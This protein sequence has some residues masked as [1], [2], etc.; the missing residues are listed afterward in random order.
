MIRRFW[1]MLTFL[2]LRQRLP[3][4]PH[5]PANKYTRADIDDSTARAFRL[6]AARDP[7]QVQI[8]MRR[9]KAKSIDD[10]M[11]ILERN[12][13]PRRADRA[14]RFKDWVTFLFGWW[15]YEPVVKPHSRRMIKEGRAENEDPTRF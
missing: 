7:R 11:M 5:R 12:R 6:S 4:V 15:D 3:L 2:T 14:K 8:L 10:L 13:K 1:R 9:H